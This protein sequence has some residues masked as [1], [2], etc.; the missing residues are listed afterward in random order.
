[1]ILYHA[2][3]ARHTQSILSN[4]ILIARAECTPARIWAVARRAYID[5]ARL[6]A[7]QR[8]GGLPSE[9]TVWPI[10]CSPHL[11]H[12]HPPWLWWTDADVPAVRLQEPFTYEEL[13]DV[14]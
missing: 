9:T 8:H 2:S 12:Y 4:G 7:I 13:P 5:W 10:Y 3:F 1:M 11:W 6:H 14:G